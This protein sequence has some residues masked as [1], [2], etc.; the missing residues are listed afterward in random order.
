MQKILLGN[1][2]VSGTETSTNSRLWELGASGH[3]GP[4]RCVTGR[5]KGHYFRWKPGYFELPDQ[6]GEERLETPRHP[7]SSFPNHT[8]PLPETFVRLGIMVSCLGRVR[9]IRGMS[10]SYIRSAPSLRHLDTEVCTYLSSFAQITVIKCLL[11][12]M[13][14]TLNPESV[15]IR[16]MNFPSTLG[17]GIPVRGK[18]RKGR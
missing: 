13:I 18:H 14:Q 7:P 10:P 2:A 12:R 5:W 8:V 17:N 9:K 11:N 3:G 1:I 6:P 4:V 16:M 15:C